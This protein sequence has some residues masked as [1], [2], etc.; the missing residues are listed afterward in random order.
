MEK[1]IIEYV[2]QAADDIVREIER[3]PGH[4]A[5]L[6]DAVDV[7]LTLDLLNPLGG[8]FAPGVEQKD[9][10]PEA[11][12]FRSMVL[13]LVAARLCDGPRVSAADCLAGRVAEES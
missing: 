10:P 1:A 13:T 9:L 8:H 4:F 11:R 6:G 7:L 5:T 3:R 2:D 12:E